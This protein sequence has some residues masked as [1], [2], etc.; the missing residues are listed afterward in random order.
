MSSK[1][2]PWALCAVTLPWLAVTPLLCAAAFSDE[3]YAIYSAVLAKTQFSHTDHNQRLVIV[4]ET[5]NPRELPVQCSKL[6]IGLQHRIKDSPRV[7]TLLDKK[8]VIGR[9][10]ILVTPQQADAWLQSRLPKI[11]TDPT[12]EKSIDP[13]PGSTDLI[14]IS[15]VFF[16]PNR[17]VAFVYVSAMCGTLCGSSGW[18]VIE[19]TDGVWR[20]LPTQSCG[21]IN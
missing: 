18:A 6:P 12:A 11:A 2:S 19:K 8:L 7:R 17:T 3:E 20:V 15:D 21:T 14:R 5:I 13:F 16:N 4:R 10:Y 1:S 9:P